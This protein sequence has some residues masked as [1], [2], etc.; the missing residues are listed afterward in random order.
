MLDNVPWLVEQPGV[1]H[2][3]SS[4]RTLAW[5]ATRG[6]RGVSS[7][8]SLAV[9]AQ[10]VP[11]PTVQVRAG[12]A[13]IP[14]T[15]PGAAQE[16]YIVRNRTPTDVTIRATGSGGKRSDAVVLRIDDTG[17]AGQ[18]P[19]DVQSYDYAKLTVIEGV[20]AS[21]TDT[22]SLNLPY[23]AI[24]L[25]RID[26]PVSTGTITAAMIKDQ[27]HIALARSKDVIYPRP[28]VGSDPATALKLT[29]TQLFP[30]GEWWPNVGGP[31]NDGVYWLDIPKWCTRM[32]IRGEWLSVSTPTQSWLGMVWLTW[33]PGALTEKPLYYT[34]GF[35]WDADESGSGY[36]QNLIVHDEVGVP[37]ALRGT[38]QPVTFRGNRVNKA[39]KAGRLTLTATSGTTLS[40][41]YLE[42]PDSDLTAD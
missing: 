10:T 11:G 38:R 41:R 37:A 34:Q 4:A 22:D 24:L 1:S 29:G 6:E 26:I 42:R 9:V 5:A 36:R 27:R 13:V 20:S 2:P 14:S 23:P 3:S 16:S 8:G 32:Q 19:P 7:A 31:A 15:Y 17:K 35:Q 28:T 12:G 33:G 21:L 25:A 30:D 40:V 39:G 18:A